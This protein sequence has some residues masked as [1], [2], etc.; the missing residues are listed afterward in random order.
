MKNQFQLEFSRR[1]EKDLERVDIRY[2]GRIVEALFVI[3][4]TPFVGKKLDGDMLGQYSLRVWPYRIVYVIQK[5]RLIVM[6]VGVPHRQGA[7]K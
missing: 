6:V 4:K 1:A 3:Q 2:R 5:Q 7:Y